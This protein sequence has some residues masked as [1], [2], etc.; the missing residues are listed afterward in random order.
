MEWLQYALV[1]LLVAILV[2]V[3]AALVLWHKASGRTKALAGRLQHL[4]WRARFELAG[5]LAA[6]ERMP[7]S[8]RAIPALL[9]LYLAMPL[10]IV[11]DFIP[12]LG[13]LDDI[14]VV[15][16]AVG[17]FARF[18]PLRIIEE[19]IA[20]LESEAGARQASG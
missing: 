13:Q 19:H 7:L 5:R 14:A 3:V 12:V 11:P 15:I 4:P 10:D 8:V 20:R 1:S 6:D 2:L 18:A 16:V 17:L 9:V